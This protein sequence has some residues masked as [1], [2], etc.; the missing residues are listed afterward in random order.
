MLLVFVSFFHEFLP[1]GRVGFK[2]NNSR[3]LKK[4]QVMPKFSGTKIHSR[5]FQSFTGSR[6]PYYFFV[7]LIFGSKVKFLGGNINLGSSRV[8]YLGKVGPGKALCVTT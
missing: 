6:S 5:I 8:N 1:I 7:T 4:F 2:K 3:F